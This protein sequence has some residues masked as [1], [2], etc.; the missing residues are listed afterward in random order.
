M[1]ISALDGAY[2]NEDADHFTVIVNA[3]ASISQSAIH[4][5][6][7]DFVV[8]CRCDVTENVFH[9]YMCDLSSSSDGTS[10]HCGKL[11]ARNGAMDSFAHVGF[12]K[13]TNH[14]DI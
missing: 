3:I 7:D 10:S 5:R 4:S 1:G 11:Q 12:E 6:Y 2:N 8:V 14:I 9:A 13:P